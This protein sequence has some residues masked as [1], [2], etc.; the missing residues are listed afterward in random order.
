MSGS[1]SKDCRRKIADTRGRR[2]NWAEAPPVA[3]WDNGSDLPLRKDF[4]SEY[5]RLL[6]A[7]WPLHYWLD[8]FGFERKLDRTLK[9]GIFYD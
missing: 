8:T 3:I 7:G 4:L 9:E 1:I 2:Q 5:E 6:F